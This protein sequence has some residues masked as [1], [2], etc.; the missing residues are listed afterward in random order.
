MMQDESMKKTD[1]CF[2]Y[3]WALALLVFCVCVC[4]RLHGSSV[5]IYNEVFPTQI[6]VEETTL[7]GALRRIRS[8]EWAVTTPKYLS[9]A[10]NGYALYSRQMSLSPTNMVLDY[11]SPVWDWTILGKPLS[12]GF[13]LFGNEVGL[14]W[15][16]CMEIILLFMT[17]LEMCLILTGRRL[18]ALLGAVMIA[19][20]PAIQWWVMPHMPPVILYAMALFDIGYRFFTA[21]GRLAKWTAAG[22]ALIA[23]VGFALSIFPSFQVPCA[24]TVLILL[25]VCL[26]RD[27]ESITFTRRDWLHLLLPA[28]G[29]L[30]I[31]GRFLLLSWEDLALL[32]NTVYPGRKLCLGG[33][34][35]LYSLFTDFS[36][37][38]LPYKDITYANNCEVATYIH[39]AP[40]FLVL[41]PRLLAC[42]KKSGDR[43]RAAGKALFWIIAAEAVYM[44]IGIPRWLGEVTLLRFC[45]RM[46]EVYG[47]TAALFTVWGFSALFR[48]PDCLSK[49]EK[50]LWPLAYGAFWLLFVKGDLRGY[51]SQITVAGHAVGTCLPALTALAF[52]VILLLALRQRRRLTAALLTLIM[53][54]CGAT[55]NPLERGIGAITNH[56]V[57]AAISEI[58][59]REPESRWLCTDC[60]FFLPNYVL[61]NGARV[62]DATNFYPDTEKWSILDP[63]GQYDDV[64]NRYANECAV[65]TEGENAVELANPD[66]IILHL[67]PESLKELSI[68]YLFTPVDHTELLAG[69]GIACE[70]I[71]GQDGYG[72]WRLNYEY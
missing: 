52:V 46:H 40:F 53:V 33:D 18:T 1:F 54:F 48:Y 27:R 57:S 13:L 51:F 69:Y 65:F 58:V 45:N 12:W 2:R 60:A 26:Y 41:S 34:R 68:R 24:Y 44:L 72:I 5:G 49:K 8:D 55:V 70:Y 36:S 42:M 4:L 66:L 31:L 9:Q 63:T 37:L 62:L 3:R 67:N 56:P 11:Y 38:F 25:T 21:K 35:G 61:A 71:T 6:T 29:A 30:L 17:A 59:Q 39:F 43:Q 20:S 10:A 32:L 7:F 14:S 15:Y 28:L 19:L 50:T 47:W 64:T 22:L 16:W 23:A